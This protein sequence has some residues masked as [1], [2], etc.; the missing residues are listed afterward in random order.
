MRRRKYWIQKA[1]KKPGTLKTYVKKRYGN[2][3]FTKRGTIK[4]EVLKKLAREK[5]TVGRRARLAL[6]LRKLNK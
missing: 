2:K 5:G 4:I 3:A 6:T 1:I